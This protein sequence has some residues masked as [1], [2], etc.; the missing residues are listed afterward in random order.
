MLHRTVAPM[1]TDSDPDRPASWPHLLSVALGAP[2]ADLHRHLAGAL[3]SRA[4]TGTLRESGRWARG[5]R[6]PW[7]PLAAGLRALGARCDC[8]ALELLS[9]DCSC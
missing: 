7:D 8:E 1:T 5:R 9:R 4:C 2:A 3:R 6:V